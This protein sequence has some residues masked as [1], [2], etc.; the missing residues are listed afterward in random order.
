MADPLRIEGPTLERFRGYLRLL[1][2]THVEKWL[3]AKIDASD[4]VQQTL[5]DAHA[6]RDQFR[7]TEEAELCAWLRQILAY[8]LADV[9]RYHG[10]AKRD[11]ARQVSLEAS[12]T[13]SF[14]R[15]DA[16]LVASQASPSQQA[17]R[18]EELLRLPAALDQLPQAQKDA[19]V[20]HHL[21]GLTLAETAE[22]L[23]KT[24]AAV[25]GLLY[26]GLRQLHKLL[27]DRE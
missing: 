17:M 5:M 18:H 25:A 7:G 12:I 20:L 1:A 11:A 23:D 19:V 2:R 3:Q 24:D 26:R 14:S 13:A 21:Q 22:R 4:L 6:K 15:V 16:L 10:R 8:N 9:V 27:A